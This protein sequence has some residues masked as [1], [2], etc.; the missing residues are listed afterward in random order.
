MMTCFN[1]NLKHYRKIRNMSQQKLAKKSK[2]SQQY[3]SLLESINR[4]ESPTLTS[5]LKLSQALKICPYALLQYECDKYC[6]NH[7]NCKLQ[8]VIQEINYISIDYEI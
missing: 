7:N 1:L 2:L 5:I 4:Q 6:K 8:Q 3:I